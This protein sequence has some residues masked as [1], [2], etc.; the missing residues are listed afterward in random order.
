MMMKWFCRM[1]VMGW[2]VLGSGLA[3]AEGAKV[4]CQYHYGGEDKEWV[5]SPTQDPLAV[6]YEKVGTWFLV[7][8]IFR[9]QPADLAMVKIIVAGNGDDG[10]V[11]VHQANYAYP[12]ATVSRGPHGFTGLNFVYEPAL[13]GEF[14]YWCRMA[15]EHS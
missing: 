6:P 5:A 1:V 13:N 3:L 9:E 7:K 8:M 14:I 12:A 11:I 10:P 4:V 15:G 2:L